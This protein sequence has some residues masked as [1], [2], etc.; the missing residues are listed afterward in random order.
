MLTNLGL[1]VVVPDMIGYGGTDAPKSPP[2]DISLY[3]FKSVSDDLAVLAKILDAPKIIL[4]GHDWGGAVVYRFAQWYPELVTHVFSVC[5]PYTPPS[6]QYI[7]TEALVNGPFPNFGYQLQFAGPE[8][9]ARFTTK[10]DIEQFINGMYS[11]KTADGKYIFNPLNGIDFSTVGKLGKTPWLDEQ[12][13]F[14]SLLGLRT[15]S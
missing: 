3:G 12:V 5:T 15:S 7:S 9:E 11:A 10:Q 2:N 8:V 6:S 1:R 4:G 13:R 14:S